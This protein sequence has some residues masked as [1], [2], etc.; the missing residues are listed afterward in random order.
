VRKPEKKRLIGRRRRKRVDNIKIYLI[1]IVWGGGVVDWIYLAH[2]GKK[3]LSLV[4]KCV[5][6]VE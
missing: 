4:T 1:E 3:W 6:F 5:G 2:D